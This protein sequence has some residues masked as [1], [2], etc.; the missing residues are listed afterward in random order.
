MKENGTRDEYR[1]GETGEI[2]NAMCELSV[3][4]DCI[5]NH[6]PLFSFFYLLVCKL[7]Y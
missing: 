6:T 7:E 3:F 5:H 1:Q 2:K 4:N